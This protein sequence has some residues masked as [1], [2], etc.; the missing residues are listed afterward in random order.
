M[1]TYFPS[2][3]SEKALFLL[4]FLHAFFLYV[5]AAA[6]RAYFGEY[7]LPRLP[8]TLTQFHSFPPSLQVRRIPLATAAWRTKRRT[9]C[10]STACRA[11]VPACAK[12]STWR[13][14][15]RLNNTTLTVEIWSKQ[16]ILKNLAQ[17][18]KIMIPNPVPL[19]CSRTPSTS[20]S[21]TSLRAA[22]GACWRAA[23]RPTRRCSCACT[24]PRPRGAAGAS[25]SRATH[26]GWPRSRQVRTYFSFRP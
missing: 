6:G 5:T 26:S 8:F 23:S 1:E 21:S 16:K 3:S 25:P 11:S 24:P 18:F 15:Y 4:P 7:Q 14:G 22:P 12:S 10:R 17:P 20:C 13:Y 9:A 19:R 2:F